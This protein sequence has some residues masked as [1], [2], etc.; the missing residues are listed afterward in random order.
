M[1]GKILLSRSRGDF[2]IMEAVVRKE[3]KEQLEEEGRRVSEEFG[4]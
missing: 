1:S 2:E 4:A 3:G